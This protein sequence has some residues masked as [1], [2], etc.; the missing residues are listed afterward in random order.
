MTLSQEH[1]IQV[2]QHWA[3][4]SISDELRVQAMEMAELRFVDISLGNWHKL[5]HTEHLVCFVYC[6]YLAIMRKDYS[7]YCMWLD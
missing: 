2:D 7:I 6:L 3:V 4:Q 1:L 5:V